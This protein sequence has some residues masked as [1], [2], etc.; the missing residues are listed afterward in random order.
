MDAN[1]IYEAIKECVALDNAKF[2]YPDCYILISKNPELYDGLAPDLNT[3]FMDI[4]M[5]AR[6]IL[7]VERLRRH[8]GMKD[9]KFGDEQ[10]IRHDLL[11]MEK[12]FW[13]IH[14]KY[15]DIKNYLATDEYPLLK[16]DFVLYTEMRHLSAKWLENELQSP[17]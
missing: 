7:Q 3:Y 15:I 16:H 13:G 11:W 8:G 9:R 14:P 12:E 10:K 17:P 6:S 2:P 5:T 4:L 1:K